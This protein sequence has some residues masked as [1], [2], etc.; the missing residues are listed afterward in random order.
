MQT[1][2]SGR[3][4]QTRSI[5]DS[6]AGLN[7]GEFGTDLLNVAQL[8]RWLAKLSWPRGA[9]L[10]PDPPA[11]IQ[12]ELFLCLVESAR[13]DMTTPEQSTDNLTESELVELANL[14][15]LP[16]SE[17]KELGVAHWQAGAKT[18]EA[19]SEKLKDAI[20]AG[21]LQLFDA[22]TLLPKPAP[23]EDTLAAQPGP[24][25]GAGLDAAQAPRHKVKNRTNPLREVIKMAESRV[26]DSADWMSVWAALVGIAKADHK[27]APLLGYVEGEGVKYVVFGEPDGVRFL[28]REALRKRLSPR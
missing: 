28:T 15:G 16:V 1:E 25:P 19:M 7:A 12:V 3:V 11:F 24:A 21:E 20:K 27:P 26:L 6:D 5:V 13:V 8:D 23:A 14:V 2:S 22:T 10:N 4:L 17:V 9:Y 18:Q